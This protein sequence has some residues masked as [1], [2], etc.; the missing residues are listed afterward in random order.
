M[1]TEIERRLH[2]VPVVPLVQCDDPATAVKLAQALVA[3]GLTVI[4]VV[5]R[6]ARAAACMQAIAELVPEAITG[7]GTILGLDQ[8]ESAIEHQAEFIVSPGLDSLVVEFCMEN[9]IPVYPGVA[10]AT[11]VQKAWNMGLRLVKFFPAEQAGGVAMIKSLASVFRDMRFMPTGGIT[12]DNIA[13]YLALP[14]VIA[15]GG[16]WLTPRDLVDKGDFAAITEI[17]RKAAISARSTRSN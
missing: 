10:T 8:A 13:S 12:Q 17:A 7:A 2:Q 1:H 14:A 4:E 16:S 9:E 11:E 3:G 15:C 5:F 6:T